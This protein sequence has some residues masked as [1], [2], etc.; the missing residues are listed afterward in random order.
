MTQAISQFTGTSE[1][2]NVLIA[3]SEIA[4]LAGDVKKAI[5]ILKGVPSD[6]AYFLQARQLLAS[7]Y[8]DHLRDRRSYAKCYADLIEAEPSFENYKLMGDALMKIRE[9]EDASLAYEKAVQLK[10][11]DE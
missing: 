1:E 9:P 5:S 6:S 3:N 10:P 4:L 2:V 7:V 8:L 11:E